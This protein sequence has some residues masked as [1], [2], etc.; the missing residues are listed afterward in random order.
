VDVAK[1]GRAAGIYVELKSILA[2]GRPVAMAN[3]CPHYSRERPHKSQVDTH[4][5][6]IAMSI[7]DI[8]KLLAEHPQGSF[9]DLMQFNGHNVGA[10]TITGVSP[11]WEMHPDTDELFL[12]LEG[13]FRLTLLEPHARALHSP[14]PGSCFVVPSGLWHKLGPPHGCSLVYFTAGRSLHSDAG[15]FSKRH[16]KLSGLGLCEIPRQ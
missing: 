2:P 10:C 1:A 15:E 11:V 5:A 16:L 14:P 12:I 7:I 13:Q 3:W 4:N 9:L 6:H 8:P